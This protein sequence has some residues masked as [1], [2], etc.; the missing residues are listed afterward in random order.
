MLSAR[1][2]R[3]RTFRFLVF[4]LAVV[5]PASKWGVCCPSLVGPRICRR[6]GGTRHIP[7]E[8]LFPQGRERFELGSSG[9]SQ[10]LGSDAV[11]G[12]PHCDLAD[13]RCARVTSL[14]CPDR[15]S[16]TLACVVLDLASQVG[17]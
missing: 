13:K 3:P 17:D 15:R 1:R 16:V 7:V 4:A 10:I 2:G 14:W 8:A 12:P 5:M 9:G 6:V 11:G